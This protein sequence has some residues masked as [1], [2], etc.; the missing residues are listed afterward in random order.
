MTRTLSPEVRDVLRLA[1]ISEDGLTLTLSGQLDRA[2]YQAT[3]KAIEALGGK[4][5]K[6]AQAHLFPKDVREVL[7]GLLEGEQLPKLPDK[8]PLDFYATPEPVVHEMLRRI[9]PWPNGSRFLEPSAGEGAIADLLWGKHSVYP[10]CVELDED[11]AQTIRRKGYRVVGTDFLTFTPEQPYDYVLMNPPFT[12]PGDP[13]AYITHIEH[14]LTCLRPGGDLVAVVPQGYAHGSRKR[15]AAF[16]A[17][18]EAN[19]QSPMQEFAPGTFKAAGTDIATCLIHLTK[20]EETR[21]KMYGEGRSSALP[22]KKTPED[23]GEAAAQ[24]FI[25]LPVEL[26]ETSDDVAPLDDSGTVEEAADPASAEPLP[27][28]QVEP[29]T[30]TFDCPECTNALPMGA[31]TCGH[32]GLRFTWMGD[33]GTPVP[34]AAPADVT[35]EPVQEMPIEEAPAPDLPC[36]S[37][38]E[39]G[40]LGLLQVP[41]HQLVRSSC[42]VRNHYD[43]AAIEELAASLRAEGQIE[44]ATGRWNAE[45]RVEIVAGES[46]RRAQLL[47]EEQGE[48]GLSLLVNV[49]ALTDAEALKISA[50]ENMR[51]RKMTPLEECEAM[52]R[53][54]EA[55]E[56]VEAIQATFGYKSPQPVADRILAARNLHAAA[57][58]ALDSGQLSLAQ[59]FVVARA[60]GEDLQKSMV[61]SARY[62]R[63]AKDLARTLTEGQFLVRTAGFNVEKSGLAVVR[64]IFDTYEPFFQD[65]AA[66]LDAQVRHAHQLAERR[67]KQGKWAF[68][69]VETQKNHFSPWDHK[70]YDGIDREAR[71]GTGLVLH[72]NLL[73]GELKEY[74]GVKLKPAKAAAQGIEVEQRTLP[75]SAYSSAHEL[76]AT[77]LRGALL[78]DTHRTLALT[79]LALIGQF[80]MAGGAP[81]VHRSAPM[82]A[83][84]PEGLQTDLDR[85]AHLVAEVL[86]LK[87]EITERALL[88]QGTKICTA[89]QADTLY[90]W[91]APRSEAELLNILNVLVAAG[92]Y[93]APYNPTDPPAALFTRLAQETGAQ[94]RLTETFRLT[95]EWLRRY[96]RHELVAL[97][98]EAGLGRALVEDCGTLKEMRARILEH[99]ERLHAEGFVPRLVRF[100][101]AGT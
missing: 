90:V 61:Q 99:A 10:D 15:V 37:E 98:E 31:D 50:T 68:V 84:M 1:T 53:M 81:N 48:T 95:D 40:T 97:A 11:R 79:V 43:P 51:R 46:R 32:C 60:P 34:E 20:P 28:I 91:L 22:F 88:F 85:L 55:G 45:G 56:S 74:E 5:N 77:A 66:A 83:P 80:S 62:G 4:W 64:D 76:R 96:P 9:W 7:N 39:P 13:Q 71:K 69:D 23:Q 18:C 29:A 16:R 25:E 92:I 35:P 59:A 44:N 63:S 42:N 100:P 86:D 67:R 82:S 6:K 78:G 72:V 75:N 41:L 36:V 27:E 8:N 54:N 73:T 47:R 52:L 93:T 89:E 87:P 49:R 12:A 14:A 30:G 2:T 33:E 21:R 101:E 58:E 70:K 24:G 17:F 94:V 65:K 19:E 3:A 26:G 57:R 38:I